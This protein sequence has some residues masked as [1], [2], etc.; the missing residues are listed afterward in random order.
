MAKRANSEGS[1]YQRKKD[2][3]WVAALVM[4]DGRRKTFYAST[5]AEASKLLTAA[6]KKKDD[7]LPLTSDRRTVQQFLEEWHAGARAGLRPRTAVRYEQLLRVHCY[8]HVGGLPLSK[9]TPAKFQ[10]L[11][12]DRLAA[13]AAPASI[14]QLRAVMK[15]GFKMGVLWGQLARN[16]LEGVSA[17]KVERKEITVLSMPEIGRFIEVAQADRLAA[18]WTLLITSGC[19]LG[20]ALALTWK[21]IDLGENA[22]MK[23]VGTLQPLPDGLTICEPKTDRSRR[24]VPLTAT[25]AEALRRHKVRQNE[26]RLAFPGTWQRPDHVFVGP[27]GSYIDGRSLRHV[28][29]PILS[30]AGLPRLRLHDLR[31][32]AISAML[33]QGIAPTVVAE[34]VGHSTPMLTL[35]V[36]GHTLEGQGRGAVAILDAALASGR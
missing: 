26:E 16:P 5:R 30:S 19:R 34:L 2:K 1:V 6:N 15:R 4:D 3:R 14:R 11:F 32:A 21:H 20:E 29:E 22:S 25:A 35:N 27:G 33:A 28:F 18:L 24:T 7:G 36:Y 12:A 8:P 9:A 31:H 13:G 10:A 23:I 17:P